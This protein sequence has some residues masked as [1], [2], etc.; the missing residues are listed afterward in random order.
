MS[1][2]MRALAAPAYGKDLQAVELPVPEPGPG[3]VRVRVVASALNPS[4]GKTLL[5]K[6][7]LLHA[8][9]FPLVVGWDLSGVVDAVGPGPPDFRA[10]QAVFGFHAYS[11]ATKFGALA[12][13]TVLPAS[14]LAPKPENV[15]H[16]TAAAAA[17]VGITAL[18]A[19]RDCGRMTVGQAALIT[20]AS[21]GV[22]SVGIGIAR[23][24]G[25]VVDAVSTGANADFVRGLGVRTVFDR[26]DEGWIG[27]V[28]HKYSVVLDAAAAFG[29]MAMRPILV[30][31]GAYV[32]TLPSAGLVGG[33]LLAPLLRR[34][35][36]LVLVRPRRADLE[37]LAQALREGLRVPIAK[38]VPIRDAAAAIADFA[39]NG[40]RGKIAIRVED[41]F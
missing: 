20:G 29:L 17:T 4:D 8:K 30:P 23:R 16:E 31:G 22:G 11:R 36:K 39:K 5:G 32:S 34:R 12:E 18:Q 28:E 13:Y 19:L 15:T 27:R 41:G 1:K 9:V 14:Q 3:E 38:V 25:G 2:T 26:G 33:F 37:W 10:G 35:C 40:A 7:T 21:G 24:L 6:I